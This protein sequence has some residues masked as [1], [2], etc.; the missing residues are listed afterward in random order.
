MKTLIDSAVS[1]APL[2]FAALALLFFG[3]RHIYRQM[4]QVAEEAKARSST[5]SRRGA[6]GCSSGILTALA[7]YGKPVGFNALV[8]EIRTEQERRRDGEYLPKGALR[9]VLT[10]LQVVRLVRMDRNGFSITD[11]G[12]EVYRRMSS[13]LNPRT[14]S[15]QVSPSTVRQHGRR[16]YSMATSRASSRAFGRVSAACR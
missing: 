3:R 10:T 4:D 15:A 6:D 12:R 2:T 9:A 8:E 14:P 13:Q 5:R 7:A 11:L 1:A 16:D